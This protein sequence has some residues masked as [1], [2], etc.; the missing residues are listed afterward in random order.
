VRSELAQLYDNTPPLSTGEWTSHCRR[1]LVRQ[2]ASLS[3]FRTPAG[4]QPAVPTIRGLD[5]M[6]A[7]IIV[8]L[9]FA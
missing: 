5:F 7:F 8:Y 2:A 4:W 6:I 1:A 3:L 9:H